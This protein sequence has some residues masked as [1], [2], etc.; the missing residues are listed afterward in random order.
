MLCDYNQNY[1]QI[2]KKY[3]EMFMQYAIS[4]ANKGWGRTGINPLVGAIVAKNNRIIG[5]G[6]HRKIGEAH[7][8]VSA[9]IAAGNRTIDATLYVNLEPCCC[10]GRTPPCVETIC[11]TKIKRVVKGDT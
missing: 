2:Q 4:L 5:Q 11:N 8:E 6:Y 3:D 9:L 10:A 1:M 7:A